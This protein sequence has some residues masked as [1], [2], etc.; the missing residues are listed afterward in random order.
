MAAWGED[1]GD[2]G[3]GDSTLDMSQAITSADEINV[4]AVAGFGDIRLIVPAGGRVEI[5]GFAL[6]AASAGRSPSARRPA[7]RS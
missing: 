6:S 3:L 4:R 7:A 1:P 5:P 2:S